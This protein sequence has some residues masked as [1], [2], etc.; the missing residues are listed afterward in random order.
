MT[1]KPSAAPGSPQSSCGVLCPMVLMGPTALGPIASFAQ[2]A[3][4]NKSNAQVS[5]G[6]VRK[7]TW[8]TRK[9]LNLALSS[10]RVTKIRGKESLGR[11]DSKQN[12]GVLETA[13]AHLTHESPGA[14]LP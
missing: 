9:A 12:Q 5:W 1:I 7:S 8:S 2:L 3:V 13:T 14:C 11:Q 6:S 4:Y 10:T